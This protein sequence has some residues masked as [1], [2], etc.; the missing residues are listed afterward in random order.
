M[1]MLSMG[2]AIVIIVAVL[3]ALLAAGW[4]SS[5]GYAGSKGLL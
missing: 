1:E 4:L 5:K 3:V 2:G